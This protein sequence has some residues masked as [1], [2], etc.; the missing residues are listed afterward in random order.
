MKPNAVKRFGAIDV[1]KY[2]FLAFMACFAII[3]LLQVFLNS[4]RVENEVR[5]SPIGLPTSVTLQN[6]ADT[7]QIGGYARAYINSLT[8]SF[9]TIFLV[10]VVVGLASYALTKLKFRGREAFIAYFFVAMSLPSFLYIVPDYF[11]MNRVGLTNSHA[12]LILL[13]TAMQIPFNMLLLRTFLAGIPREV[14]E[15]G[16]IDG[17]N[18]LQALLY[19][20]LP[21]AKPIFLTVALLVFVNTWNEYLWANTFIIDDALKSVSTRFVKFVG[22]FS[23]SMARIYTASCIAMGPVI[24]MYL[25]FNRRFIEGMTSGSVKG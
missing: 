4:F 2:I 14:E 24:F 8:V 20:T 9:I 13:Y 15:A 3:P 19:I 25:I 12:G 22:E 18:E 23:T 10:L 5:S 21:I 7:W 1:I 6:Y 16:K 11:M 17:C